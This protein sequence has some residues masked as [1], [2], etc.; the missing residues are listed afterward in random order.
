MMFGWLLPGANWCG[1][2]ELKVT[3]I[4]T[5]INS[6]CSLWPAGQQGPSP[7]PLA[8]GA[9]DS[10]SSPWHQWLLPRCKVCRRDL[11]SSLFSLGFLVS[12]K[13]HSANVCALFF[14]CCIAS[15]L[16]LILMCL[17]S[18]LL[19]NCIASSLC[20]I[21]MCPQSALLYYSL[22]VSFPCVCSRLY[23]LQSL[24]AQQEWRVPGLQNRILEYLKPL[25]NHPFKN[26]RER[27]GRCAPL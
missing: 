16:C 12:S 18:A 4:R 7:P 8:T 1:G 11:L 3:F 24:L 27:I 10:E 23:L 22:S 15:S 9:N 17:Q 13:K 2:L 5:H 26:V 20:L 6:S 14:N 19:Y 25:L 21:L